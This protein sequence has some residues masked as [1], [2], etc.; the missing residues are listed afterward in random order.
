MEKKITNS[1]KINYIRKSC[2]WFKQIE[3][4]L[5]NEGKLN[6]FNEIAKELFPDIL[7][8]YDKLFCTISSYFFDVRELKIMSDPKTITKYYNQ[9]IIY[10]S[11]IN[12][13]M[14]ELKKLY[15]NKR[16]IEIG[17]PNT[18]RLQ[19]KGINLSDFI[20]KD[21]Y[22]TEKYYNPLTLKQGNVTP[23]LMGVA[24]QTY[25][26]IK[27]NIFE[28][29][30]VDYTTEWNNLAD[31]YNYWKNFKK[32][33]DNE[34]IDFCILYADLVAHTRTY[35][36]FDY[37]DVKNITKNDRYNL[38]LMVNNI[39]KFMAKKNLK[40]KYSEVAFKYTEIVER[41]EYFIENVCFGD[42][43]YITDNGNILDLKCC[44][45]NKPV[46]ALSQQL[47]YYIMGCLGYNNKHIERTY[48]ESMKEVGYYNPILDTYQ[49]IKV[50]EL[51]KQFKTAFLKRVME[52]PLQLN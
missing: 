35:R 46:Q 15:G 5:N 43:D 19:T 47:L 30:L 1:E 23:Q 48:F 45:A 49:Y 3:E 17:K 38:L 2:N 11:Y 16:I 12:Q 7:K 9:I 26:D 10:R 22:K 50:N 29:S 20:N 36:I 24:V 44:K 32:V 27:N 31:D 18:V 40:V 8:D 13:I 4:K 41:E 14:K 42:L 39:N 37:Y 6:Q 33:D 34:V 25:Y 52:H 28:P 21:T 51:S